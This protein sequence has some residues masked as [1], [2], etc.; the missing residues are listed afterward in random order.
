MVERAEE[1]GPGG[2]VWYLAT[3]PC[4]VCGAGILQKNKYRKKRMCSQECLNEF[5]R[6]RYSATREKVTCKTCGVEF[7]LRGDMP[8]DRKYCSRA[9]YHQGRV[10]DAREMRVCVVCGKEFAIRAK[11]PQKTC[12]WE[13]GTANPAYAEMRRRNLS[14]P[15]SRSCPVSE[16]AGKVLGR[17]EALQE[18]FGDGPYL[19][20]VVAEALQCS[21]YYAHRRLA[22]HGV[23]VD[24]DLGDD[25]FR[26]EVEEVLTGAGVLDV[27]RSATLPGEGLT[28]DFYVPDKKMALNVVSTLRGM[29]RRDDR[30]RES[31]AAFQAEVTLCHVFEYE[32]YDPNYRPKVEA[33]I[34]HLINGDARRVYARSCVV[35]EVGAKECGD[36]L[37]VNHLQ[38]DGVASVR[39]GL[40]R[41]E[42][43]VAVMTFARPRFT[44]QYEWEM[45]RF[46]SLVGT[47][48]VGGASKLFQHFVRTWE[49]S[50][51]VS[52]SDLA[53]TTGRLYPKLGFTLSHISKPSFAWTDGEQVLSRHKTPPKG[54]PGF[55]R[56]FDCGNLVFAWEG[57]VS[58]E[59]VGVAAQSVF[60]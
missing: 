49:P 57:D 9:C 56:V 8:K 47:V 12:S 21:P 29:K 3:T 43:L 52:Y 20:G 45:A 59:T 58:R 1:K 19:A 2:P 37:R 24:G 33:R 7:E 60:L 35:R 34:K 27:Q 26:R 28:V 54:A 46:C 5:N 36:F 31:M 55:V 4:E 50:S 38:G 11:L 17:K 41:G 40:F 14:N 25:V 13:C 42:E 30:F 15:E 18:V 51:V 10:E 32:W 44:K 23:D 6:A 53:R 22:D 16:R 48:V 39:L